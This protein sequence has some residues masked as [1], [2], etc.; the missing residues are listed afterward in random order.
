MTD[1]YPNS[2]Y[3]RKTANPREDIRTWTFE[4][5]HVEEESEGF[6]LW[7]NDRYESKIT[8]KLRRGQ[9]V[10]VRTLLNNGENPLNWAYL[11]ESGD[12]ILNFDGDPSSLKEVLYM[13][14]EKRITV[15]V[16]VTRQSAGL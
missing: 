4:D 11:M 5:V 12:Y 6:I 14:V 9:R 8:I 15:R 7:V 2:K 1:K 3:A 13:L 16:G 10:P